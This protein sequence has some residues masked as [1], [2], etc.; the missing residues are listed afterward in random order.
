MVVSIGYL[1]RA[2]LSLI[3]SLWDGIVTAEIV[4]RKAAIL[5]GE[6]QKTLRI[7]GTRLGGEDD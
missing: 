5:D 2:D 7:P 1:P 4:G 6:A 3:V